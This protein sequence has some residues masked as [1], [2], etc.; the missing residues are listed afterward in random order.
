MAKLFITGSTDGLGLLAAQS[1][2]GQ[3]HDVV[4]HARN[5]ARA[6]EAM[7]QVPGAQGVAT[8]DLSD[9]DE[10]GRLA[11][12][13][14]EMGTFDAIIHNAGV[15]QTSARNIF[16][17]NTL[18]PFML[19]SLIHRPRR[20]IYLSSGMHLQGRPRLESFTSAL[21][22]I[23]YADSKLHVLLLAFAV[24]R[25]WKGIFANG[26]DPGWV[27]TRMGGHGAPDDLHKG[28][29]TQ[30]WLAVSDDAATKVSGK[31]FYH[32]NQKR[33][34]PLASDSDLQEE[35]LRACTKLTGVGLS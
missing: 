19:T 31:Y 32:Q 25:K 9:I 21:T 20:L 14:N 7:K 34:N 4:L 2:V 1:L 24:A 11:D 16:T 12:Q 10:T 13:V 17:V 15:Y 28:Y 27:P 30:A 23:T 6:R 18:A 22:G 8:G 29:Q 35:F 5:H 26:V 33:H 3:G